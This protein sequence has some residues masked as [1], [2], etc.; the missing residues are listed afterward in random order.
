M[1]RGKLKDGWI[2]SWL[3]GCGAIKLASGVW[4]HQENLSKTCCSNIKQGAKCVSFEPD[5]LR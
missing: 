3:V 5:P 4:H 1:Q 2:K